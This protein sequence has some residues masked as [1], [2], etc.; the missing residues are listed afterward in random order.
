MCLDYIWINS[1]PAEIESGLRPE[2]VPMLPL[3]TIYNMDCN[4]LL[5]AIPENTVDLVI[6]DPPYFRVYG[7]FDFG[8]FPSE[9][10]YLTWC[11]TWLLNC[12]RVLKENGTLILWGS[13]GKRQI[14][15]ARLAIMLED[16]HILLRQNWVTQKNTRGI[17]T[18]SNYMSCREDF[19]FLTK[20]T[21]YTF[22]IPYTEEKTNRKD[23]GRNGKPRRS[24]FKRVSNVWAD[25]SEASQSASERCAHPT[26]KAQKL[27]DRLIQTHSNPGDLVLVPFVGAGSEI[28]SAIK[29]NR[30]YI[31]SEKDGTYYKLALKRIVALIPSDGSP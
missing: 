2:E 17:G 1:A 11:R 22:N 30:R 6:A 19:L 18:K 28:V 16:E 31:G 12:K 9:Q 24:E 21:D 25:V 8:V 10:E 5:P 26:V 3:N 29:N 20:S 14:T 13:V 4:E 23:M 15:F 27:C 7:E